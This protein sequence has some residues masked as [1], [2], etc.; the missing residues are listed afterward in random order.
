[1]T[2]RLVQRPDGRWAEQAPPDCEACS[3]AWDGT[4]G[5]VLVGN[6][7]DRRTYECQGCGHVT[8]LGSQGRAPQPMMAPDGEQVR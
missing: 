4:A 5:R 1:M 2:S 3:L 7:C 6:H 8:G